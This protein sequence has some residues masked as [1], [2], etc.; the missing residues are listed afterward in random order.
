MNN[1]AN[2][3]VEGLERLGLIA[4]RIRQNQGSVPQI[5]IDLILQE[6]RD[7]YMTCLHIEKDNTVVDMTD[8]LNLDLGAAAK[9]AAE[10]KRLA[11][12]AAAKKAAEE[13]RLAEEAAAKK[14][15]EEKRLAEEAAAKKA[16]EEKRLAE[17]AAAKK[18]AEEKRLAEEAAA[19]KAAEEK[20][21]A[22]EA[23]AK[24]AAE[25]KRLAEEA[26]AKK[27]AEEKRLAE[28]AAAKKA[29]EE[30]HLA[31]EAAAKKAAEEK[32]LAEEAAAKKAAEIAATT[33]A[34]LAAS[35]LKPQFVPEKIGSKAETKPQNMMEELSGNPNDQLFADE[36]VAPKAEKP[37]EASLFDYLSMD[38]TPEQP[39][40]QTIGDALNQNARNVEQQL[41]NKVNSKKVAD[42]RTVISINDKFLFMNQLF[43]NNLKEYNDFIMRLN[44]LSDREEALAYVAEVSEANK[45]KEN[46][47]AVV[48]FNKVFD[49]KF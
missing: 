19:K 33:A 37:R 16:A 42:L 46:S 5:E 1:H 13:K 2:S 29:A 26:A 3:L 47:S 7:L 34:A 15:A 12:E 36:P 6:L 4:T 35:E 44:E 25:E 23:A 40:V 49:R 17:E 41:E 20:R 43:H 39:K 21:L 18:A 31:E 27:A 45:W 22:E 8:T 48:N 32:R 28:E 9:K 11:E 38:R 14:A 30:K 10:E 24:K